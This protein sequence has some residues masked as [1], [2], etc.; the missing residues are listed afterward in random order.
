MPTYILYSYSYAIH[1]SF[2]IAPKFIGIQ[3]EFA[4]TE[5]VF[6]ERNRMEIV[7]QRKDAG[8]KQSREKGAGKTSKWAP[9]CLAKLLS[10]RR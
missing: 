7:N 3:F 1:I 6:R 8:M 9:T 2:C 10:S 4:D 5:K